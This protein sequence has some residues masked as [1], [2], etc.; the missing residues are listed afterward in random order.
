MQSDRQTGPEAGGKSPQGGHSRR[1]PTPCRSRLN[2]IGRVRQE[3]V[4]VYKAARAGDR[5]RAYELARTAIASGGTG[6][7]LFDIV[8]NR[9]IGHGGESRGALESLRLLVGSFWEPIRTP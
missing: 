3:L 2:T 7:V 9:L 5:D 1:T 8:A 4:R 6:A